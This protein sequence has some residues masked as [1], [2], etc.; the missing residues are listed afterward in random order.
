MDTAK[1][2]YE[3][4]KHLFDEALTFRLKGSNDEANKLYYLLNIITDQCKT[5]DELNRKLKKC[6]NK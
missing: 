5:I 3:N 4:H 6:W 2:F 1:E